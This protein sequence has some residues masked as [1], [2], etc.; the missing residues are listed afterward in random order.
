[1][2]I[3]SNRMQKSGGGSGSRPKRKLGAAAE[4][5]GP[6]FYVCSSYGECPHA[7]RDKK[8]NAPVKFEIPDRA[9]FDCPGTGGKCKVEEWVAP[10]PKPLPWGLIGG[11]AGLLA[12]V[13]LVVLWMAPWKQPQISIPGPVA[14]ELAKIGQPQTVDVRIENLG[15]ATLI[16]KGAAI[17][18]GDF[19]VALPKNE[20]EEGE[21]TVI[22]VTYDPVERGSSAAQLKIASN[23]KKQREI[24]VPVSGFAVIHDSAWLLD[25]WEK[26]NKPLFE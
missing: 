9:K 2:A 26:L 17:D 4:K 12:V 13:T 25:E 1:M 11:G 14:F 19:K 24:V 6:T 21:S 8:T 23:D 22:R 7:Q 15:N 10:P 18:S 20:V 16:L 5:S 3:T